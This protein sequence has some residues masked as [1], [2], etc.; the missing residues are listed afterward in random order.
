[1][2]FSRFC[3]LFDQIWGRCCLGELL[4]ASTSEAG[5]PFA[6]LIYP[7]E[8]HMSRSGTIAPT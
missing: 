3:G 6:T 5:K 1:L 4:K 8:R 2:R 7:D